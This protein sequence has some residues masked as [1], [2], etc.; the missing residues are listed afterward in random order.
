MRFGGFGEVYDDRLQFM[1]RH[2]ALQHDESL[3]AGDVSRAWLVWSCAAEAAL[4]VC[5]R[6]RKVRLLLLWGI[7][8]SALF[9][10]CGGSLGS[11]VY[12]GYWFCWCL[13]SY[14]Q[15][16]GYGGVPFAGYALLAEVGGG[17]IFVTL[18]EFPGSHKKSACMFQWRM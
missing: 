5:Q 11:C 7:G 13:P 3:D 10:F 4:V 12:G 2:D 14:S 6:G 1:S 17:I 8:G 16:L 9:G 15:G 18:V